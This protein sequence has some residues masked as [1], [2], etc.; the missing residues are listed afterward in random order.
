[1]DTRVTVAVIYY[2]STGNVFELAKAAVTAAEEAGADVRLRKVRELAPA[3][4]IASNQGWSDR[5]A[6]SHPARWSW[7]R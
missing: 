2:S 1:M 6:R 7:P 4:A 3:E 5:T